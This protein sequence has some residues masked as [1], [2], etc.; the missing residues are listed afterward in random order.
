M[1]TEVKERPILFSG[2]MVRAILE[3]SKTQ[4][5]RVVKPQPEPAPVTSNNVGD[6]WWGDWRTGHRDGSWHFFKPG[7]CLTG[8]HCPY[9]DV[10]DRLWVRET[11][12]AV[13]D[14]AA[15]NRDVRKWG[16]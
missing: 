9:G 4:T 15:R 1:K 7:V 8:W 16:K 12:R 14:P 13:E 10:G 3:G 2:E 5:R 6:V 11:W